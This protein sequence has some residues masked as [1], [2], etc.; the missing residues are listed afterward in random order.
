M[1]LDG[2]PRPCL[3]IFNA[4]EDEAIWTLPSLCPCSAWTLRLDTA[5]EGGPSGREVDANGVRAAAR[6]M[7]VLI[8]QETTP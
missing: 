2:D 8:A 4:T 1:L 6:S 3:L 5:A 7:M